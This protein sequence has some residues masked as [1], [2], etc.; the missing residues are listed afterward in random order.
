MES[1]AW[2]SQYGPRTLLSYNTKEL[3]SVDLSIMFLV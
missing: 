3:T 2:L 1:V